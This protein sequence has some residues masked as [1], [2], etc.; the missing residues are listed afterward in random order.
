MRCYIYR[1]II[2]K[3]VKAHVFEM[4]NAKKIEIKAKGNKF[5]KL[6]WVQYFQ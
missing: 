3:K 2:K 5:T 1:K 6:K 4:D